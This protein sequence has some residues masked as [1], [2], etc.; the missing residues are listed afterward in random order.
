V[1]DVAGVPER[2]V[3]QPPAVD[4]PAADPG[5]DDHPEQAAGPLPGPDPMLA[6]GQRL[7]VVVDQRR[8]PEPLLE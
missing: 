6:E 8:P 7:G 2:A 5:R 3:D 4:D 1:A